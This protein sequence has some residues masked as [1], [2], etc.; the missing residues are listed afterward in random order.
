MKIKNTYTIDPSMLALD[1]AIQLQKA[2]GFL[3][4]YPNDKALAGFGRGCM[5]TT[6]QMIKWQVW[7]NPA[8]IPLIVNEY[9]RISVAYKIKKN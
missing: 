3:D 7:N 8:F 6:R 5:S 2:R 1:L 4:N 9:R